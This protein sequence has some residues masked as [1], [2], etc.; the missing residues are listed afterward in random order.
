MES[1]VYLNMA[2]IKKNWMVIRAFCTY[3]VTVK[4]QR[5]DRF[6]IFVLYHLVCKNQKLIFVL[7]IIRNLL[8]CLRDFNVQWNLF[9]E[10]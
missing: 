4:I 7:F 6:L 3:R 2:G 1:V 8:K 5:I 10:L 9:S